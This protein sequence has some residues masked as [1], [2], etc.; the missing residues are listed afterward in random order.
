M[1]EQHIHYGNFSKAQR[2]HYTSHNN[3]G[4]LQHPIF[5]N[6]QILEIET[7]QRQS[8]TDRSYETNESNG[9]L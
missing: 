5:I 1:Q 8:E 6:G 7:K 9:Y 4:R 2:T 3:S